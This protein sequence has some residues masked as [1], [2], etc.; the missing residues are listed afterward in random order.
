MYRMCAAV[1]KRSRSRAFSTM[2]KLGIAD[3]TLADKRVLMRVDFNVPFSNVRDCGARVGARWPA[4]PR[5]LHVGVTNARAHTCA[6]VSPVY[7]LLPLA[8]RAVLL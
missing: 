7:R 4:P 1:T 3:V 6:A 2:N 8:P 5:A